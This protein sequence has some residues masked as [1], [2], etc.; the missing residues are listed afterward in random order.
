MWEHDALRAN[1]GTRLVLVVRGGFAMA[2]GVLILARPI[3]AVVALALMI[4]VWALVNGVSET[5]CA[6]ALRPLRYWWVLLLSGTVGIV[7][8]LA[9]LLDYPT[10]PLTFAVAWVAFAMLTTGLTALSIARWTHVAGW[11]GRLPS[12]LGVACILAAIVAAVYP[13]ATLTALLGVTAA[14]AIVSGLMMLVGAAEAH[15]DPRASL[16]PPPAR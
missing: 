13:A 11:P 1:S 14:V 12:A 3:V 9:S 16:D 6:F 5:I 15:D 8:G 10:L 2:I 4:A 7:F